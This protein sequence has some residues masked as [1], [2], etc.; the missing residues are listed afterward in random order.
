M[1]TKLTAALA[2]AFLPI[3][4]GAAQPTF[5]EK[6]NAA[7]KDVL[8]A[9]Q[10]TS[11][12]VIQSNSSPGQAVTECQLKMENALLSMVS[13]NNKLTNVWLHFDSNSLGHPTD[14]M[15]AGGVL[16]RAARGVSYG[17]YL[18]VSTQA[19][20]KSSDFHWNDVCVNDEQS[21]SALCVSKERETIFQLTLKPIQ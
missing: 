17:N 16:I 4:V 15:R 20:K 14:A 5:K 13:K 12:R 19:F 6:Y 2:I 21:A 9:L 7:A 18:E 11:C 3:A 8:P 1:T 10:T